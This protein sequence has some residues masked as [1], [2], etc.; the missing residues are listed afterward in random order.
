MRVVS[1]N[2]RQAKPGVYLV[3]ITLVCFIANEHTTKCSCFYHT[4]LFKMHKMHCIYI[5]VM[6]YVSVFI[7]KL[8]INSAVCFKWIDETCWN[9]LLLL[10]PNCYEVIAM[11]ATSC[12][13]GCVIGMSYTEI[14]KAVS[15]WASC[16]IRKIG[17]CACAR[18]GR[19][20]FP[21]TAGQFPLSW[22][23]ET[24]PAFPAHAQ[25]TILCIW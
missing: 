12:C 16:Q 3:D 14:N 15:Q 18:N 9:N 5:Y 23:P 7:S 25:P 22:W 24:F 20:V 11:V 8:G 19:N 4:C 21:A 2:A 17:S 6:K 13:C 10:V 1:L